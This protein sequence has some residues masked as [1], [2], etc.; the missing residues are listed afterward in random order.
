[1]KE[2]TTP[3]ENAPVK[4]YSMSTIKAH[5]NI[6]TNLHSFA[7]LTKTGSWPIDRFL[8]SAVVT[9]FHFKAPAY[10]IIRQSSNVCNLP[11]LGLLYHPDVWPMSW[12]VYGSI[13]YFYQIKN[14][15]AKLK[16]T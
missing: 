10:H 8:I 13:R 9:K 6:T 16:L 5:D 2:R 15:T 7:K 3:T 14:V 1:M 4:L 12:N 11:A